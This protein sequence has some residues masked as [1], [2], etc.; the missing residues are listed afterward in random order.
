MNLSD[1]ILRFCHKHQISK[2]ELADCA[3]ISRSNLYRI[4][5]HESIPSLLQ[6]TKLA[7]AM[8]VHPQ[9][10]VQLEWQR[11]D[12]SGLL[13]NVHPLILSDQPNL[14]ID[15]ASDCSGFISE[16]VPDGS[17]VM[18]GERF[19]KTWKIQNMGKTVWENRYLRWYSPEEDGEEDRDKEIKGAE[20]LANRLLLKPVQAKIPIPVT[21]PGECVVLSVELIAPS[22]PAVAICYWKMYDE[23]DNLCF[24]EY[25]GLSALVNVVSNQLANAGFLHQA[26]PLDQR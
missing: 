21:Q 19:T 12:L 10:L 5:N 14:C 18:T 13:K 2:Q 25:V 3:D 4:L 24:P 23:Q 15:V 22:I 20:I 17:V 9:Y 11:Y 6:L 7:I 26:N 16:T 8:Q 1:F